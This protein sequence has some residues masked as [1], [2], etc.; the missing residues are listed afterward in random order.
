MTEQNKMTLDE[1]IDFYRD[2]STANLFN[3]LQVFVGIAINGD[4]SGGSASWHSGLSF[5]TKDEFIEDMQEAK[6]DDDV[7]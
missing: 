5:Q 6:D 7:D 3:D 4:P 1:A 2:M